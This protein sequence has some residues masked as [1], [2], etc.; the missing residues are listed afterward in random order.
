M[1]NLFLVGLLTIL[2]PPF[3]APAGPGS[4]LP[5]AYDSQDA[6]LPCSQSV[7]EQA[8]LIRKAQ[9]RKYPIRRLEFIGNERIRDSVLRR[10][11]LLQEGELFTR[12]ILIKSLINVSKLK[13]IYPVRLRNVIV[14]LDYQEKT[15]DVVICF[16]ERAQSAGREI[17]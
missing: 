14:K 2:L 11:I 15:I 3:E 6:N 4:D 9:T 8:A 13:L 17:L 1:L 12:G 7:A 10:R 16:K 5:A